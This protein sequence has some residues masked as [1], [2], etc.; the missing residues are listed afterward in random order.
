M[1]SSEPTTTS[2]A[3]SGQQLRGAL[4][5]NADDWGRDR[6]TTERTLECLGAGTV[7]S[8]SAMVFMEDSERAAAIA[9]EHRVDAG[10]HLNFTTPFS[11]ASAPTTLVEHQRRLA[12]FLRRHRFAPAIFHPGLSRS[13][14]YVVKSQ[15]EEFR[16][17]YG[18]VPD[19]LDGHHHMHL[20]MNVVLGNLLPSGTLVRR[21]FSFR[22]GE[23]SIGNR[24]YRSVID[25]RL[26]RRHD[27]MDFLFALPPLEP[28]ARL[29]RIFSLARQFAVELET[30]PVDPVEYRFLMSSELRREADLPLVRGFAAARS[31]HRT[32]HNN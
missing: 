12:S 10:L 21:N 20:C 8:V 22:A 17:L 7:S 32:A 26:R 13:F 2:P 18:A 16:R 23:K 11:S 3:D 29:Q 25:R 19:R 14:E 31:R 28:R 15:V 6:E 4:V 27:I 30:H 24:L 1:A 9:R 5:I